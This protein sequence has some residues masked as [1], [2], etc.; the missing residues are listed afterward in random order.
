MC[1]A[2]KLLAQQAQQAQQA[3]PGGKAPA[4]TASIS[5]QAP[6]GFREPDLLSSHTPTPTATSATT[7][8]TATTTTP[9][10]STAAIL[11]ASTTTTATSDNP[12][13]SAFSPFEQF[14]E[15]EMR[16][17]MN[18][19]LHLSLGYYTST[20]RGALLLDI[21][22]KL[23][24]KHDQDASPSRATNDEDATRETTCPSMSWLPLSRVHA[25]C[26]GSNG[27]A[28]APPLPAKEWCA[29][30]AAVVVYDPAAE[31]VVFLVDPSSS[32]SWLTRFDFRPYVDVSPPKPTAN[33][34][35]ITVVTPP[36]T[37]PTPV[38]VS[39]PLQRRPGRLPP[40]RNKS[41]VG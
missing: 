38:A 16:P 39:E 20:G 2:L 17:A 41:S 3:Q 35:P 7:T 23:P 5:L 8:A 1:P 36:T 11:A 40:L 12:A 30:R 13:Q 22:Q 37:L 25:L 34:N 21:T 18:R 19:L 32:C 14:V 29:L 28:L 4:P 10:P 33:T 31:I 27:D 15:K 26:T 24:F 6:T 9:T